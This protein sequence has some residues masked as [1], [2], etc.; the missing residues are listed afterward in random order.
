MIAQSVFDKQTVNSLRLKK[1]GYSYALHATTV[2]TKYRGCS[3]FERTYGASRL[4]A[5]A[6][7]WA[8]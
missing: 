8:D 3:G 1:R 6:A 4:W 2:F 7:F 5:L